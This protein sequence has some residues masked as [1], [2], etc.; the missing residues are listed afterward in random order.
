MNLVSATPNLVE[1]SLAVLNASGTVQDSVLSGPL[2]VALAIAFIAGLVSF[3]SP[4]CLPLVP[5]YLGYVA[6][7]AG[8]PRSAAAEAT[9]TVTSKTSRNGSAHSAALVAIRARVL[10]GTLLFVLG[11]AAVFT[12]Y[13]AAFG[14]FGSMLVTHQEVLVRGAGV[15]TI[16]MGL[17]FMGVLNIVP[18]LSRTLKPSVKPR[19]GLAGAPLLGGIF[20][21]GWT[22]CIGPT[23]AAVLT[24]ST[25]TASAERGALLTFIYSL[26]IGLPFIA[27]AVSFGRVATA[28]A[29]MSRHMRQVNQLGGVLLVIVGLAQVTGLWSSAMAELQVVI[30]GWQPPL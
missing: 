25:T 26:G 21:V 3:F 16:A 27:A 17:A 5:V 2:L 29:W 14:Q 6:G 28:F 19:V 23:L 8:D 22:P 9:G 24:L 10:L 11:F 7:L 13:G 1:P 4:C 20:A 15:V 18:L 12:G 30:G